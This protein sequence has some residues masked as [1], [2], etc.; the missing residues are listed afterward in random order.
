MHAAIKNQPLPAE[1]EKGP[2][3]LA[4][5]KFRS[6]CERGRFTLVIGFGNLL[7]G[8]DGMG[9]RLGD[10][11]ANTIEDGSTRV[12]AVQQLAPELAEPISDA[13]LV[14][15]IDASCRLPPG[16]WRCDEIQANPKSIG[17]LGHYF[18]PEGLLAYAEALFHAKPVAFLVS[19]GAESFDYGKDL[20][21]TG[22]KALSE[23]EKHLR[24][25]LLPTRS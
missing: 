12:L 20:T 1:R 6:R 16:S 23:I 7:R 5:N 18:S 4:L 15:F 14:I 22:E 9:H 2:R 8:D 3:L 13:E 25:E 10:R 21:P 19:I 24:L 11:L 17:A